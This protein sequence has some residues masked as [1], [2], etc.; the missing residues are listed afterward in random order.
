MGIHQS[1]ALKV[2]P[3]HLTRLLHPEQTQ[4]GGRHVAQGAARPERGSIG[5]HRNQRN[6]I[7][8]MRRVNSS[9]GGVDHHFAVAVIG[10]DQHSGSCLVCA[11]EDPS[12]A[13]IDRLHRP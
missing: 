8:G 2:S 10:C 12:Q 4:D 5:A 7:G 3:C 6:R 13:L 1:H 11:G 9:G